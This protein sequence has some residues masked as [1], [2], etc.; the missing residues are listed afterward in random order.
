MI[1]DW[2]FCARTARRDFARVNHSLDGSSRHRA[3]FFVDQKLTVFTD[4]DD[5]ELRLA[6]LE[7]GTSRYVSKENLLSI[8]DFLK[9]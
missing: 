4:H 7:A 1:V 6:A 2:V 8:L 9:Q 3:G 5:G